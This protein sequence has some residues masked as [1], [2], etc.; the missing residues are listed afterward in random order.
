MTCTKIFSSSS[1]SVKEGGL[2]GSKGRIIPAN[3]P[4]E[5][6]LSHG[7]PNLPRLSQVRAAHWQPDI[8]DECTHH[9]NYA[10]TFFVAATCTLPGPAKI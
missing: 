2:S 1:C 9:S 3:F 10:M 5:L 6:C 8:S 7:A 4:E